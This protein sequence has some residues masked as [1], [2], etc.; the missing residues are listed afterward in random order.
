MA[1]VL[2]VKPADAIAFLTHVQYARR[3][4]AHEYRRLQVAVDWHQGKKRDSTVTQA[5]YVSRLA[6]FMHGTRVLRIDSIDK[7]I[8]RED[9]LA[10]LKLRLNKYGLIVQCKLVRPK[11]RYEQ[12]A[13]YSNEVVLEF[14]SA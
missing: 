5:R 14:A 7:R 2:F 10:V 3:T 11:H 4:S 8:Q 1:L 9:L 13:Q 6:L 12:E